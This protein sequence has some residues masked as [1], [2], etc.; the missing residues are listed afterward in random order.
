MLWIF[1]LSQ[2]QITSILSQAKGNG[3]FTHLDEASIE[4]LKDNIMNTVGSQSKDAILRPFVVDTTGA[5]GLCD[6]Q[7][8]G[9]KSFDLFVFQALLIEVYGIALI[10]SYSGMEVLLGDP[11]GDIFSALLIGSLGCAVVFTS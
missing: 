1:P 5:G 6:S 3:P 11:V 9:L 7:E 4:P 10:A 8:T 2:L